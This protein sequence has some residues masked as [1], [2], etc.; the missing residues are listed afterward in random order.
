MPNDECCEMFSYA[1]IS[2]LIDKVDIYR[3]EYWFSKEV[4]D[5]DE[6]VYGEISDRLHY[7]PFCGAQL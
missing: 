3:E 4:Y 7:C 2:K 6:E 5:E 1:L